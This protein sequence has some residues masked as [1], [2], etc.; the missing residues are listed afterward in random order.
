[1]RKTVT[2]SRPRRIVLR[3][4]NGLLESVGMGIC[5]QSWRLAG[6]ISLSYQHDYAEPASRTARDH[7]A[8]RWHSHRVGPGGTRGVLSRPDT[9]IGVSVRRLRRRDEWT[10]PAGP[11]YRRSGRSAG[12]ALAGRC[13][14]SARALE[15]WPRNWHLHLPAPPRRLPLHGLQLSAGA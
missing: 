1:S 13:V 3:A 7:A 14:W 2:V 4:P 11:C 10:S 6:S 5:G 9:P 15:R 8:G 12:V